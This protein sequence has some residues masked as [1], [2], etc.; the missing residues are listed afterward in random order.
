MIEKVEQCLKAASVDEALGEAAAVVAVA[1]PDGSEEKNLRLGMDRTREPWMGS[2]A[3]LGIHGVGGQESLR[4]RSGR[5]AR[6]NP[7]ERA[8]RMARQLAVVREP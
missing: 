2:G 7:M 5:M 4:S 8:V 1:A 6:N 3:G